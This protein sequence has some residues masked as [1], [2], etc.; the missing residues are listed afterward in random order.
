MAADKNQRQVRIAEQA[1]LH[2]ICILLIQS[3]ATFVYLQDG[4][5]VNQ[6]PSNDHAASNCRT[7]NFRPHPQAIQSQRHSG[8]IPILCTVLDG[9]RQHFMLH[10]MIERSNSTAVNQNTTA[11]RTEIDLK[12]NQAVKKI[13]NLK[14][15]GRRIKLVLSKLLFQ[16]KMIE[17]S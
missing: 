5:I 12:V 14:D 1:F 16:A 2:D 7:S 17:E 6:S 15:V 8:Q 9:P 4:T 13:D 3:S 10:T 11:I